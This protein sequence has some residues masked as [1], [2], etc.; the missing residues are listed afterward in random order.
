MSYLW[1]ALAVAIVLP[2]SLFPL[3]LR[4]FQKIVRPRRRIADEPVTIV[5]SL[6][7][8]ERIIAEKIKNFK[9]LQ[10]DVRILFGLDGCS[11]R[12]EHIILAEARDRRI[13]YR[14][15]PRS[16]KSKVLNGLLMEVETPLVVLTDA[17][18]MFRPEAILRLRD[19]M[20][21]GVGVVVGKLVL[22]DAAGSSGE[23]FYW[24]FETWLKTRESGWGSVMG[25]NGAIYL[26]RRDLFEE[27]PKYAI[28]DDFMISM[29]IYEKGYDV[30]YAPEAVAEEESSPGD[31]GEFKRHVR[32]G[33]GHVGAFRYLWR[34]L[35]PLRFK[36]F[37]FYF[38]HRV[39]R[40]LAPVLMIGLAGVSWFGGGWMRTSFWIQMVGYC[41][42]AAIIGLKIRWKPL[43]VP[44]YFVMINAAL[45]V[46][47]VRYA[48]GLQSITWK[49]TERN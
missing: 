44:T 43:Y 8:E 7:N 26:I 47:Y 37:V 4:I 49:S 41:A 18:S 36:R 13:Q 40:W 10:G 24:R 46:G 15:F 29:K 20:A 35:N 23:G 34:L 27:L 6:Y 9:K 11:D 17:N 38:C 12:T 42:S 39:L 48:L 19:H 3:G 16:G 2:Y 28:N 33:A 25:A 21:E 22:T 1:F 31:T 32:D 14:N 45:L 5:C 30:V